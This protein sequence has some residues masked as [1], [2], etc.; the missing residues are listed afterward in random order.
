M[1]HTI[2]IWE[3]LKERDSEG[4]FRHRIASR[5]QLT[6]EEICR[7]EAAKHFQGIDPDD[8]YEYYAEI[9]ETKH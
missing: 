6:E 4:K 9:E 3:K 5:Y 8:E 2:V 1:E 7:N